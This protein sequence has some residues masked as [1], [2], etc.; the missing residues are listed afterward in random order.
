[1]LRASLD[2]ADTEE[3][4]SFKGL[5]FSEHTF[6]SSPDKNEIKVRFVRPEGAELVPCVYYINGGGMATLSCYD[7][8]YR[9][10]ARVIA[11]QGVAVTMVDFRNCISPSSVLEVAPSLRA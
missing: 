1:M 5:S 9:A 2:V 3:V 11:E 4:A 10:W 7:A 6:I 8:N